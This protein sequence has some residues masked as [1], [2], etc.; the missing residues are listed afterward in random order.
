[1][2]SL[3]SRFGL[4]RSELIY[5][6]KPFN[7]RRLRRFYGQF[8]HLGDLCFDIGAHVGNRTRAFL[9]NGAHVMAVEP[10][11]S[12]AVY[13][14]RRFGA[15]PRFTLIPKAI[16]AQPGIGA[17]HINRLNPTISTLAPVSW[18]SAMARAAARREHWDLQIPVEVITLNQLI[19]QYG[20]PH[21]CKIDVEGFEDQVLAGLSYPL[22]A[23]SFEFISFEKNIAW[24]C[25]R[26]LQS[27]GAYRFNWSIGER[28]CLEAPD[29]VDADGIEQTI[30]AMGSRIISGDVYARL[31]SGCRPAPLRIR[32]VA[33]GLDRAMSQ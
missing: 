28:L 31:N 13:L 25:I 23:L 9:D 11:P 20:L 30:Q 27:L 19:E 5:F 17:L 18:R 7:R 14:R 29:W 3:K 16:G 32:P 1:M 33:E 8:V 21:F 2:N 24:A 10:Q 22:P 15:H 12:C 4:L 26:R 6:W